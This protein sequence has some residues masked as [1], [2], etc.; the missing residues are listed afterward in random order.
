MLSYLLAGLI[1]SIIYAR[2]RAIEWEKAGWLGMSAMPAALGGA[3]A[4]NWAPAALL[5]GLIGVLTIACGL[6]A[7]A[8]SPQHDSSDP[9][10]ISA[11]ALAG[12]G[13]LTG[14][15]SAAS[16][17]GG[18]LILVPILL[19]LKLP[20]L[21]AVGLSQAIQVPIALV[22]S[23]G[24]FASGTLD[25]ALGGLLSLGLAGGSW[26]G[27]T[28]AHRFPRA[29]LHRTVCLLL[30]IVGASIAT[31]LTLELVSLKGFG[32]SARRS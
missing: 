11:S 6:N 24:N 2:A 17:T 9:P 21:T 14:F 10:T 13:A 22:A 25:L 27:A 16:G 18:P 4:A 19:H 28:L 29:F 20:V 31:K 1:G 26:A 23:A 30:I 15:L 8:A 7:L 12:I 5:E 3:L 32:I